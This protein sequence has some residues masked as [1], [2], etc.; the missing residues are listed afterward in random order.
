MS[1]DRIGNYR[2]RENG[3]K[4]NIFDKVNEIK[5]HL[6]DIIPEI[7]SDKLIV[8][9]SHCRAYYEGKLHYG[10]RN[11]PE[12]LQRTRELTANERIVYEYLLKNKLNPSTTYRWFIATRLPQDVR[13]KLA[14]GEIGQKQAM[15]I[16]ANRRNAKMS[17]IG[18]LMMEEIREIIQ[19]LEWE[20]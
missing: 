16:S 15:L 1:Y 4:I 9:L 7:E 14:K 17:Q 12:N 10:R 2:I 5:Q 11:V 6:K 19:K 18:L 8:I 20:G 3:R 13:E